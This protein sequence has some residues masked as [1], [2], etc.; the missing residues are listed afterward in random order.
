[1]KICVV[2][3]ASWEEDE[4]AVGGDVPFEMLVPLEFRVK[5]LLNEGRVALANASTLK[6]L[7][8]P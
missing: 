2:V 5:A 6:N 8:G 4:A 3:G 1:M 7:L